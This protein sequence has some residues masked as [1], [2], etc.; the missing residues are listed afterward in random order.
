MKDYNK[1]PGR[2]DLPM[3]WPASIDPLDRFEE[4]SLIRRWKNT[5]DTAARD[6]VIQANIRFTVSMAKGFQG[7]GL[8]LCDLVAEGILGLIIALDR[9]DPNRGY[10]FISYAVWWIRQKI[11]V[12]THGDRDVTLPVN[13]LQIYRRYRSLEQ[14]LLREGKDAIFE[15]ITHEMD[16]NADQAHGLMMMVMSNF[17]WQTVVDYYKQHDRANDSNIPPFIVDPDAL[18]ALGALEKTQVAQERAEK[19]AALLG[20]LGERERYIIAR[21]YGL[22]DEPPQ[23]FNEIG[24]HLNLT[25]ER[26]RQ[27]QVKIFN[28]LEKID[29]LEIL[30]AEIEV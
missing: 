6:R 11:Q 24:R 4:L 14:A 9:F 30:H 29:M 8:P 2:S 19:I 28:K 15:A 23:T 25:R 21:H 26:V 12:A 5:G 7:R 1:K 13:F 17:S 10:K 20:D 3:P 18:D 27:I 22:D 16:L